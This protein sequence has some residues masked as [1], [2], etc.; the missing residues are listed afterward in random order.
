M[1]P[2]Q[3]VATNAGLQTVQ[4]W[5]TIVSAGQA[6]AAGQQL[7]FQVQT[8]DNS[9]FTT[10][11]T[12]SVDGT[13]S[14]QVAPGATGTAHVTIALQDTG[15]GLTSAFQTFDI[16]V[17][18]TPG[19][20]PAPLVANPTTVV[21]ASITTTYIAASQTYSTSLNLARYESNGSLDSTFG[22][23]G[24]V[25]VLQGS[26][27]S[28]VTS[29]LVEPDGTILVAG[30][31]SNIGFLVRL[32]ANGTLDTT[33]N[34]NG[35]LPLPSFTEVTAVAVQA[36]G[37][38]L[39]SDQGGVARF[40]T[41]GTPDLSFG[42][43]GVANAGELAGTGAS[44]LTL[45]SNG[46]IYVG[47]GG[48][49][50]EWNTGGQSVAIDWV[51]LNNVNTINIT[52]NPSGAV[53]ASGPAPSTYASTGFVAEFTANLQLDE[54]FGQQGA[55]VSYCCSPVLFRGTCFAAG[56]HRWT[57][58]GGA[59]ERSAAVDRRLGHDHQRIRTQRRREQHLLHGGDQRPQ[60]FFQPAC[61]VDRRTL[62]LCGRPQRHGHDR[63]Y[64]NVAR[65]AKYVA[66][67]D[68]FRHRGRPLAKSSASSGRRQ[69]R[70]GR[71]G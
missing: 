26:G 3:D 7:G 36:D 15:Q 63:S 9:L 17:S 46:N 49:I 50:E 54:N 35:Y 69:F 13:L 71:S 2:N 61:R 45:T 33:F 12:I 70:R 64:R 23:G 56:L 28:S 16:N 5:A 58:S 59:E 19:Q 51:Q 31:E 40:N 41:D 1:G 21:K 57:Q 30:Q 27:L 47:W 29:T 34:G 6:G 14:Y 55:G 67:A 65:L 42:Q 11:P 48:T 22:N 32:T 62:E 52:V 18:A 10:L 68:V 38:I 20:P 43:Q 53:V 66:D 60:F 39:A 25:N 8:D 37:K 4:N 24:Q 44:A